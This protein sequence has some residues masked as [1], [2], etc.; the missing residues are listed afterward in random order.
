MT[1]Q[2][3]LLD[4]I[5]KE[6]ATS[7]VEYNATEAALADLRTQYAGVQYDVTTKK[8]DEDARKARQ[9]LVKLRT[10]LEKKRS[11]IKQPAIDYAKLIDAEAK[12]IT[13]E[14][15][16]LEEPID[17]QIKAEEQ[18]KA[19]VARIEAE[20]QAE[21]KRIDDARIAKIRFY[22]SEIAKLPE[23]SFRDKADDIRNTLDGLQ[24]HVIDEE[25]YAEFVTD[26]MTVR[27][28]A[29]EQLEALL[30]A[31]QT[32]EA[33]AERVAREAEILA[34]QQKELAEQKAAQEAEMKA[35]REAFEKDMAAAKADM[36]KKQAELE[37]QIAAAAEADKQKEE[38]LLE[39]VVEVPAA[40]DGDM[41]PTQ[42]GATA[43]LES[44]TE[45]DL[46]AEAPGRDDGAEPDVIASET[47][48]TKTEAAHAEIARLTG[49][50]MLQ[51]AEKVA[52]AGFEVFAAELRDAGMA[53]IDGKFN[54]KIA[55]A[56][57][58][59]FYDADLEMARISR[60]LADVIVTI[61]P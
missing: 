2:N 51:M 5:P 24:D 12:R 35:Q 29:V 34:A 27:D 3:E 50:Q 8:G 4:P 18:R 16:L 30:Q 39:P 33:E 61:L 58:Q 53:A 32:A 40:G 31:A 55:V 45:A 23:A 52:A 20:H 17:A 14:I 46:S 54:E 28:T 57:M 19:E 6:A 9:T 44:L 56:D 49:L 37:K 25:R 48:Y 13:A 1:T 43:F 60:E 38:K 10:S 26:A 36:A 7:I 41:F 22:I 21:L 15:K 47:P 42:P 59:A 11:E